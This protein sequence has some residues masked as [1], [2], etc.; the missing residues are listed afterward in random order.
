MRSTS[1]SK[2]T[3]GGVRIAAID[4]RLASNAGRIH[5]VHLAAYAQEAALL[6]A[7]SFPPLE[8]T[9]RD[10]QAAQERFVAAFDGLRLVGAVSVGPDEETG[11]M[12]IASLAV[13]PAAQRRGIATLLMA[14]VVKRHGD[15]PMTV[16]TGAGNAPALALYAAFG[17]VECRRWFVGRE[18]LE[19]VR[20]RRP[21]PASAERERRVSR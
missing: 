5:A 21:G 14:A 17:F 12:N 8:R 3:Q 2:A 9:V 18:P 13:A 4:H 11:A 19:M 6:G 1:I 15:Q 7:A 16:E 10:V 20:L